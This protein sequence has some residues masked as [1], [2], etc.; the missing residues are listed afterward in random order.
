[1]AEA[2]GTIILPATSWQQL[3]EA[4]FHAGRVTHAFDRVLAIAGHVP[5][6][7]RLPRN[8]EYLLVWDMMQLHRAMKTAGQEARPYHVQA[9][10]GEDLVLDSDVVGGRIKTSILLFAVCENFNVFA[11]ARG[12]MAA[13]GKSYQGATLGRPIAEAVPAA[14]A[15]HQIVYGLLSRALVDKHR[16]GFS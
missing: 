13:G 16:L 1:M 11:D 14:N 4:R 5:D 12:M 9:Q 8:S 10:A 6:H 15:A 7:S 2:G 3:E